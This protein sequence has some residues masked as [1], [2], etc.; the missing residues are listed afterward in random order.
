MP[1]FARLPRRRRC[2]RAVGILTHPPAPSWIGGATRRGAGGADD[3]AADTALASAGEG[4]G[5]LDLPVPAGELAIRPVIASSGGSSRTRAATLWHPTSLSHPR[6]AG[7][8]DRQIHRASRSIGDR[9]IR[10]ASA[11]GAASPAAPGSGFPNS[12]V[13]LRRRGERSGT[14]GARG[15]TDQGARTS[16]RRRSTGGPRFRPELP[17]PT[18]RLA[19]P[20][21][22]T[23]IAGVDLHRRATPLLPEHAALVPTTSL[24]VVAKA[25]P[26]SRPPPSKTSALAVEDRRARGR[27]PAPPAPR[28]LA[29]RLVDTLPGAVQPPPA[30]VPVRGRPGRRIVGQRPPPAAGP[31]HGEDG[32]HDLP[33]IVDGGKGGRRPRPPGPAPPAT[34]TRNRTGRSGTAGGA[35]GASARGG[36]MRLP[37]Q[38]STP[39]HTGPYSPTGVRR[40]PGAN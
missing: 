16:A 22:G 15:P 28:P 39:F 1:P 30:D 31:Q 20:G 4:R 36:T 3:R 32:V 27:R 13:S 8:P 25:A 9:T 18:N 6:R 11:V 26:T 24:G 14:R 34:P 5:R 19:W 33:P 23:G 7:L 12:L 10:G 35:R 37:C 40:A 21:M 17:R 2:A 29:Q 38:S